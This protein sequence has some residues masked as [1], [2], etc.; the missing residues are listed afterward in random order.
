MYSLQV[1]VGK[2]TGKK[3]QFAIEDR[4]DDRKAVLVACRGVWVLT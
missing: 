4:L 2:M 1:S 3:V